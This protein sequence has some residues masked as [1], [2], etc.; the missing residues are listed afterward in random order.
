MR[1]ISARFVSAH[2]LYN[3]ARKQVPKTENTVIRLNFSG[4]NKKALTYSDA[5]S[6]R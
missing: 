6:I 3:D 5:A 1:E 2:Y 4:T